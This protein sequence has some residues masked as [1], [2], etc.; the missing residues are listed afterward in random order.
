MFNSYVHVLLPDNIYD[1]QLVSLINLQS[2]LY[3]IMW[4]YKII[5][6]IIILNL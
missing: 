3:Y 5:I 1:Q 2:K 4:A 6:I